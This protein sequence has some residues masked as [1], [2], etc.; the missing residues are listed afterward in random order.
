MARIILRLHVTPY[1]E[2]DRSVVHTFENYNQSY[3]AC[4]RACV[5]ECVRGNLYVVDERESRRVSHGT[6]SYWFVQL[7][8]TGIEDEWVRNGTTDS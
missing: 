8:Y 6:I 3:Y 7:L 1:E 5:R 2:S 4:V